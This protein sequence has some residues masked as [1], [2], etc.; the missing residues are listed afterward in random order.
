MRILNDEQPQ[1][2]ANIL[3]KMPAAN[4]SQVVSNL[5]IDTQADVLQRLVEL[6]K[7]PI[8]E[9]EYV[10][11]ELL[12]WISGE[13]EASVERRELIS[14]MSTV[15]TSAPLITRQ[16][17]LSNLAK[18]KSSFAQDLSERTGID[19]AQLEPTIHCDQK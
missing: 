4:A 19:I 12:E 8:T 1:T 3:S 7:V 2:S 13:I 17:L 6:E 16:K 10:Q 11:E 14:R 15:I 5:S 9:A 18:T